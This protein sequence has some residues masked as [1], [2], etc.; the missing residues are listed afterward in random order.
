M[1]AK[2]LREQFFLSKVQFKDLLPR[3][4]LNWQQRLRRPLPDSVKL[5]R[6]Y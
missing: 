4:Q 1:F 2:N 6:F 3:L 5:A